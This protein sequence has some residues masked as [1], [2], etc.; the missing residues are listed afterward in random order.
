MATPETTVQTTMAEDRAGKVDY[1]QQINLDEFDFSN[2]RVLITGGASGLGEGTARMF[3]AKG[4]YVVI[5]DKSITL[6]QALEQELLTSGLKAK[7]IE[8]DVSSWTSQVAMFAEALEFFPGKEVD[9]LVACAGV[10]GDIWSLAPEDPKDLLQSVWSPPST[11]SMS[12]GLIGSWY[13]VNLAAKYCMGL[14]KK[15]KSTSKPA[16]LSKSIILISSTAGYRSLAILPDYTASKWGV[17]GLFRNLRTALPAF[18]VRINV[19]APYFIPTR[20][21]A[22]MVPVLQKQGVAMGKVETFVEGVARLTADDTVNG[23]F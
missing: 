3:A 13:S 8:V 7:F 2:K 20:M 21:T 1:S 16:R 17:R 22:P 9:V 12:I 11:S 19:L 4:A 15:E 23:E 18:G 14:H 5:A 10:A 6:G